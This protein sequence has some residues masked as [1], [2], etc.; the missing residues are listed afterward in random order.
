M[1]DIIFS[2]LEI[3]VMLFTAIAMR[4]VIPYMRIKITSLVNETTWEIIKKEVKSVEQTIVGS[5][6]GIIKKEEVAIRVTSW[7]HK[8]GIII[9][10]EQISNLI[11]AAVY[12]MK[13]EGNNN[14]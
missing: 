1:H 3:L 4:Y 13:N 2:I 7:A 10:Q 14:G 6:K 11:E 9:T 12:V 8:H 5:K